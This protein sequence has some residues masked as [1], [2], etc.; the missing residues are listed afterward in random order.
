[1]VK[2]CIV[3]VWFVAL[4]SSVGGLKYFRERYHINLRNGSRKL[5]LPEYN[6]G[7]FFSD[8]SSEYCRRSQSKCNMLF[9]G[10]FLKISG[11]FGGRSILCL[12]K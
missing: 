10:L 1:V 9:T 6:E 5:Y 8:L 7:F 4:C 3:V 12:G 11:Y 2:I